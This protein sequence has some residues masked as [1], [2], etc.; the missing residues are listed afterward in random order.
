MNDLSRLDPI[1]LK[2]KGFLT[3]PLVGPN[4]ITI[5]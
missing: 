2:L 5:N 3:G 4:T 1:L